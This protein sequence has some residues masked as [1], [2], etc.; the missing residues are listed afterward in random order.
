M[1]VSH[2]SRT[3]ALTLG[4]LKVALLALIPQSAFA[5]QYTLQRSSEGADL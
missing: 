4:V 1:T 3:F 2:R 5:Q